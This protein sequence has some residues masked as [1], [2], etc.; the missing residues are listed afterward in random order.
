MSDIFNSIL[1]VV[2]PIGGLIGFIFIIIE[3][4]YSFVVKRNKE[5]IEYL[6]KS[7]VARQLENISKEK[8]SK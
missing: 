2:V 7:E 5:L 8:D 1:N 4:V 6:V 3:L